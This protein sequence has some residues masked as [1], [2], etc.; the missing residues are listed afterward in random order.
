MQLNGNSVDCLSGSAPHDNLPSDWQLLH[1]KSGLRSFM[2]VSIGP[3]TKPWGA[4]M[5]GQKEAVTCLSGPKWRVWPNV[6]AV[7]LVHLV[8]HWQTV[9]LC[10]LLRQA[11]AME[12]RV[13]MIGVLLKGAQAFL[14]RAVNIRVGTRL[15]LLDKRS[16]KALL[17]ELGAQSSSRDNASSLVASEMELPGTL[18]ASSLSINKAR[19]IRDVATYCQ[20]TAR[21]ARDVFTQP[22]QLVSSLVVV[23]LVHGDR[24]PLAALY[25][26][27]EAP[28]DFANIQEPLL[29]GSV[30]ACVWWTAC[31]TPFALNRCLPCRHSH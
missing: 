28:N 2:V 16:T 30:V 12:D 31:T 24:P 13:A 3:V 14:E 21:P 18:L 5:I 20:S 15:A 7:A 23:P 26:T 17:F 22:S 27:M 4:L 9:S 8:R 29:V 6:A 11:V 19:F 10:S 25:L 1:N